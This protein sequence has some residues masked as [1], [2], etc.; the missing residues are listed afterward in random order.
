ME[1]RTKYILGGLG[2]LAVA[3]AASKQR[4]GPGYDPFP[5]DSNF[6]GDLEARQ[7]AMRA[8]PRVR[9]FQEQFGRTGLQARDCGCGGS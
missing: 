7:I 6:S 9:R 5:N 3:V 2:L 4:G 8:A 1:P